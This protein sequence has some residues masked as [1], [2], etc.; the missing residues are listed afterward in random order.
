[1]SHLVQRRITCALLSM[2]LVGGCATEQLRVDPDAGERDVAA[3]LEGVGRAN[4]GLVAS[5][6]AVIEFPRTRRPCCVLGVDLKVALG[7]LP[8]PGIALWNVVDPTE[9]GPHR[10]YNGYL[11][12][13]VVGSENNGLVYT[14]RGGFIDV[15]HV[16]DNADNTI[17]LVSAFSRS[18]ETGTTIDLVPQGASRRI[19]LRPIEAETIERNGRLPLAVAVAQWT[20][21]QIAIWHEIATFYGYGS[22][23]GWEKISAF[24]PEDLYSNLI[25]ARLAGAIALA[26]SAP[27]ELEWDASMN[28]A[29]RPALE[30]LEVVPVDQTRAALRAVDGAW[31]DSTKRI[32]DWTLVRRRHFEIGPEVH[33]WRLEDASPGSRGAIE[34]LASCR[35]G[36]GPLVMQ[37]AD[38]FGGIAFHDYLTTEFQVGNALAR[39]GFPLPRPGSRRVTQDDFPAIIAAIRE[40]NARTFGDG[41]DAP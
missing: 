36:D 3:A 4:P 9:I 14:C 15:A 25:G 39:A 18:L 27:S 24:S 21:F 1:M 11:S 16:R 20:A 19:Q 41:A 33:P 22:V 8:I 26:K 28:E 31:W 32:P 40:A 30:Y 35:E 38:E 10:Y 29:L 6:I 7:R 5:D 12:L 37:V 23:D 2:F 34:P 17:A 13:R